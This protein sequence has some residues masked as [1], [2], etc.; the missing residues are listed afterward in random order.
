MHTEKNKPSQQLKLAVNK[1]ELSG[2]YLER[3]SSLSTYNSTFVLTYF[4]I[5]TFFV[6]ISN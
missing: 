2:E 6:S 1:R 3:E 4:F 5:F